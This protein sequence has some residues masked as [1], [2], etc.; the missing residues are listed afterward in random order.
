MS[1]RLCITLVLFFLCFC[2]ASTQWVLLKVHIS[3]QGSSCSKEQVPL[4]RHIL[5]TVETPQPIPLLSIPDP[6]ILSHV[7]PVCPLINHS[8][9]MTECAWDRLARSLFYMCE[10]LHPIVCYNCKIHYC[11]MLHSQ[12]QRYLLSKGSPWHVI[13]RAFFLRTQILPCDIFLL[14]WATKAEEE[15]TT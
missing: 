6:L 1:A 12:T 2:S 10:A 14:H 3:T 15:R 5:L 13:S 4:H 7:V 11:S 8:V 9:H